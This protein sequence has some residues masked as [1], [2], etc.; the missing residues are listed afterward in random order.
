MTFD[1]LPTRV[2]WTGEGEPTVEVRG[3]PA[4][5]RL[6]VL[7]LGREVTGRPVA[8]D[9]VIAVGRLAPGGYGIEVHAGSQIVR[10]ALEVRGDRPSPVRYGFV[11]DYRPGRDVDA[12]SDNIRRL[13]LSD[14]QFYDWGYRHADLLGGGEQYADALGQPISLATVRS[15]ID[16]AHRAGAHALGY[17][18]VY[19]V[20]NDEWPAWQH[21]ALL[22]ASGTP[23]SLGD[24]LRLVDPAD[25]GWLAHF[26]ADLEAA[27][28]RLGFDGFHLDQYG[29]P[30]QAV[31]PDGRRIDLADSFAAVIGAARAAMP[32]S[33]LV[34]NNVNNFPTWRTGRCAQDA[35][36][37]EVWPPHTT[38]GHLADVARSAH[39][40][41]GGKPVVIAA[42]QHVYTTAAVAEADRATAFTMST[43]LSHGA[44][45]L[46][47][48]EA[49]RI[50]VD[51]Y[52]VR[53]HPVAPSTGAL[54]R[55]WYDF[56]VEHV[57]LLYDT[58]FVDM[59]GALAG[60]YN[61]D[62]DVTY[63]DV[64][65]TEVPTAGAVWRRIVGSGDR[66]VMHLVNLVEQDDTEWD[67]PRKPVCRLADGTLR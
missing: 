33:R 61:G 19:G 50:L 47:C 43:L 17:A 46:L 40:A 11:T 37:V 42:Y 56:L 55:R 15:L 58:S 34:F 10:T 26:V 30:K 21:A 60:A 36:Y 8:Q 54:L 9:G 24:F 2:A 62:C 4:P 18:A 64:S 44:T 1:V 12:V 29:Y 52:Y 65:V 53:N 38:L 6:R 45:Q 31:R 41:G 51:P 5:G 35:V 39:A 13:H 59:T 27:N 49:D 63:P 23:C 28:D 16:A 32:D 20:G 7:H 14:I 22:T 57:E 25:T 67:S 3:L 48:G 66:L